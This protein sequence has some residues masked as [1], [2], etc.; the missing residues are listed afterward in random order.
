MLSEDGT[1]VW[2][3]DGRPLGAETF[4]GFV[5]TKDPSEASTE[6][7]LAVIATLTFADG[8][9]PAPTWEPGDIVVDNAGPDFWPQG[10]WYF[11]DTDQ[12]Y[13][14]DCYEALPGLT[15]SAEVRPALPQAGP[16]EVFAWT[17]GNPHA[18]AASGGVIEVHR[19]AGD[20][21]PQPVGLNYQA[22]PGVWQ[23][24]GTYD[25]EPGAFLKVMSTVGGNTVADAYR[26]VPR[27]GTTV[28]AV[29]TP[30]P[31]G[32]L[33]SNNPPSPEQQVTT[34]DLA[35]RIGLTDPWYRP[36]TMQYTQ[37]SF[38]DCEAF[39]REGCG[40]TRDGFEAIVAYEAMT[41]T[42]RVSS[43]Y[44][45]VGIQGL[46]QLD[47]SM[48]GQPHPQRVYL[49]GVDG[50]KVLYYPNGAW[51]F[52][53]YAA[54]GQPASDVPLTNEQA[55]TL[56]TLAPKYSTLSIVGDGGR[57]TFYGLGSTVAPTEAD[58]A[59]LLALADALAAAKR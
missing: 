41:L 28:E 15:V 14:Q 25:L 52:L 47:P 35:A 56:Q 12:R 55:K 24:L 9:A 7:V 58:R 48:F 21:A 2:S 57:I 42:Y 13:A 59:A 23:S 31:T 18:M 50:G 49:S 22:N 27:P 44:Q 33:V 5:R 4:G 6:T 20:P 11:L 40:G 3:L 16:Y 51:R 8:P 34:G 54:D 37:K 17:C 26:F 38:D 1:Q 46:E 36:A 29:P 43:D 10:D 30:L 45:L 32:P 53:R 39:P 19:A